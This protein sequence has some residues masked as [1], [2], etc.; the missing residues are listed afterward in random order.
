MDSTVTSPGPAARSADPADA[1]LDPDPRPAAIPITD[2]LRRV[3][4]DRRSA[5]RLGLV[6]LLV[7]TALLYLWDLGASGWANSFYAAAAQAGSE[8]W[9]A[10]FFGASDAG[11]AITVDKTP[12][13]L[14]PMALSIRV[15][16]LSSWSLLVP[17]AL[18]GVG[19]VA[20][21]HATVRRA[22]GSATAGLL[23]GAALA[24][25]PVATLMFRFDNPDA[26]LVL[27]LLAAAWATLRALESV[28]PVRWLALA[29]ALVGL[30]F[31]AKMLQA[32]LVLP[33]LAATYA[34]FATAPWWK[35]VGHLL[36]AFGAMVV[37]GG[38]WIAI[39]ELVPEGSRPYV[40]GSQDN[41]ILELAL[42]YNG[43]GRLNGDEEGSVG[44][45]G[46]WGTAG[47]LRLFTEAL[48]DQI[49][50]LL[51]AALV[52]G[53][54][55][56]WFARGLERARAVRAALVLMLGW[57]LVTGTT[58]SLMQGIFHE[59]YTVALA[60]AVALLAAVGGWV[61]WRVRA[62]LVASGVL[63]GTLALTATWAFV[64][65][66]RSGWMPWLRWTVAVVGLAAA[67]LVVGARHLPRRAATAVAS[68][69]VVAALAGPAA[70][71]AA[72][73]A[74]PH[75]GSIVT[76]G[77]ATAGGTGPGAGR[78]R[79]TPAGGGG[80]GAV[81]GL[82][83]GSDPTE[84]VTTLLQQDADAFTWAA[85]TV[86]SNSASGYQLASEEPVMA[87]GGFNGTDPSP[88]LEEFQTYVAN[89]E[90]HWFVAGGGQLGGGPG[91]AGD[92][93]TRSTASAITAW[94]EENFTATTIDGVTL[95]DL[96][97]GVR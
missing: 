8:S 66:E 42:G 85:A 9:S 91:G 69:A 2:R 75:T 11:G 29:G 47:P 80:G 90:V 26:A 61:L 40:G 92:D 44:G 30:A 10:F 3:R 33:A 64:L 7:G 70:Y 28:H 35:R 21:L 22:T 79:A 34:V 57:L 94:V 45:G 41:S 62:S 36:V 67:L 58:F 19:A 43:L 6:V 37:A 71:S 13:S 68:V 23:A 86:G 76:A 46:G 31:L 87:I 32:F 50:W 56:L 24:L 93:E 20:L 83:E 53:V 51:P 49:S 15:F 4:L 96:A 89:G 48:G 1:R 16:G 63:G 52:L 74:T 59:Y 60:P 17:Q 78:G 38:W 65:L 39:V 81:G 18:M 25:T 5:E 77:P 97:G 14:W 27:L 54:A 84:A 72:T 73:A 88:T 95:Y 12:L 55:G 82:L